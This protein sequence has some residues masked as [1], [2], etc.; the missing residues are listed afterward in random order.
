MKFDSSEYLISKRDMLL[1]IAN[2]S[3]QL[4][5]IAKYTD[6]Y[7]YNR[8]VINR[9]VSKKN[10]IVFMGD[11]IGAG[12]GDPNNLGFIQRL[13]SNFDYFYGITNSVVTDIDGQLSTGWAAVIGGEGVGKALRY[14]NNSSSIIRHCKFPWDAAYNDK[15]EDKVK[16]IYSKRPDGGNFEIGYCDIN[17]ANPVVLETL[18][19]LGDKQDGILSNEI[20]IPASK[21]CMIKP[22][23]D[24]KAYFNAFSFT[25]KNSKLLFDI[26]AIGGM[27]ASEYSNEDLLT[28]IKCGNYNTFI[29]QLFAN[30]GTG[31]GYFPKA[32]Y[33]LNEA[34][35][36]GMDILIPIACGSRFVESNIDWDIAKQQQYTLAE[37]YDALVIDYDILFGKFTRA[38]A[39]GLISDDVH[40]SSLGH[41]VMCNVLCNEVFKFDNVLNENITN[42]YDSRDDSHSGVYYNKKIKFMEPVFI[43][44]ELYKSN[45][46][47]IESIRPYVVNRQIIDEAQLG[48]GVKGDI[49][50]VGNAIFVS[51]GGA[52]NRPTLIPKNSNPDDMAPMWAP[53]ALW[54][55]ERDGRETIYY[56]RHKTVDGTYT[57]KKL[58]LENII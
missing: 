40:P 55:D 12:T 48:D 31:E 33:I 43:N 29:W 57:F 23:L 1:E 30:D 37:K 10:N 58:V 27:S 47:D 50:V 36:L 22:I 34:K 16:V 46:G 44:A 42:I 38:S 53:T 35:K 56:V 28:T 3:Q 15:T 54:V 21:V 18:S 7:I 8:H 24:N 45:S 9:I 14:S 11:S 39:Q 25:S 4:A 19:S 5:D 41:N 49:Q 32:D 51:N 26:F 6:D 20:T 52:Y 13:K 2:N 17:E